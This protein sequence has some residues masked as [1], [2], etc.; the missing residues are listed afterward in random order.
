MKAFF[1][2]AFFILHGYGFSQTASLSKKEAEHKASLLFYQSLSKRYSDLE[3]CLK[4]SREIEK[5][6]SATNSKVISAYKKGCLAIYFLEKYKLENAQKAAIASEKLFY[7][8]HLFKEQALMQSVLG[9]IAQ[10]K[11]DYVKASAY[12]FSSTKIADSIGYDYVKI[13]NNK[14]LAFV[15]LDQKNFKKAYSYV[16]KAAEIAKKTN[17]SVELGFTEGVL[18]EIYRSDNKADKANFHFQKGYD[19]FEKANLDF[20]KAWT[21][22]NWSLLYNN[23]LLKAHTMQLR[24]QKF[25]NKTAPNN[26]MSI[27]N[28]YNIAY[29]FIDLYE[30]GNHLKNNPLFN[31]PKEKLMDSAFIYINRSLAIAEKEDNLQWQMFCYGTL[32]ALY[33]SKRDFDNYLKCNEAYHNLKDSIYSQDN[34]N[35]IAELE[36]AGELELK[37]KQIEL[38]RITI[39]NKERQK[40]YF[41]AGLILLGI[42]GLLLLYQNKVRQK[43]NEKLRKLNAELE[44]ANRTKTRFFSILNHD[45]RSP[46]SNLIHFLHLQKENPELLDEETRIKMQQKTI[47]GAENLLSSMEDLLLWSKGQMEHF[48]PQPEPLEVSKLFDDIA[49]Y[50]G[51]EQ[52]VFHF[53]NPSNLTLITDENY[54]KTILRNLTSNAIKAMQN[55]AIPSAAEGKIIRWRAWQEDNH[56]YLAIT[57]N[58]PGSTHEK[59]KALYDDKEVV[60]IKTGLGMHLIRDLAKAINCTIHVDSE[61]GKGTTITLRL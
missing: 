24:A 15:F 39:E 44:L 38:N 61:L 2:F 3:G 4:L 60:G 20:G 28:Q 6:E 47:T 1:C 45:L 12:F 41:I 53:E 16:F 27:A 33:Y 25:W 55:T 42:I 19:Y 13:L 7:A 10:N 58:G 34:K 36:V 9:R 43:H 31:V 49:L 32:N 23:D 21:L 29:N 5:L 26:V 50:F 35:K 8:N 51:G 52:V 37:N 30:K 17:N 14:N 40:W 54:L 57:D 59:F 22:T 18:A 56:T 46:V 48:Q 11:T